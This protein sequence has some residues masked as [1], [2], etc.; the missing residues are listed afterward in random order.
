MMFAGISFHALE[1]GTNTNVECDVCHLV[2]AADSK[3]ANIA[4]AYAH[5]VRAHPDVYEAK[6]GTQPDPDHVKHMLYGLAEGFI[7]MTEIGPFE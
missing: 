1:V 2:M 5:V 4:A 3:T 6:V 7:E